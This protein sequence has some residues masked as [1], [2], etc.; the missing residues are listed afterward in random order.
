MGYCISYEEGTIKIKKD[1]MK[2]ILQTLSDYFKSNTLRW[3]DGFDINEVDFG[4]TKEEHSWDEDYEEDELMSIEDIWSD[5]RYE[6][7]EEDNFYIITDFLGEKYG[8][9]D[10]FFKIIAPYCENGF[11]QFS[12]EDGEHFR[13]IIKDG[14]F[15]EKYAELS[16]E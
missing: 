11:L 2:I 6:I 9:D 3:V 1:N 10:T 5:L 13:F 15:E 16:W 7:K 8:D 4:E 14:V 12:G